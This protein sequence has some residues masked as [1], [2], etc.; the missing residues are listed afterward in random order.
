MAQIYMVDVNNR[1]GCTN[2]SDILIK[3]T[4]DNDY[5]AKKIF[6]VEV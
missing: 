4:E 6:G 5:I 3:T 2:I 1:D